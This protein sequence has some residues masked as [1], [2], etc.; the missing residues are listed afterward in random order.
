[1]LYTIAI[2]NLRLQVSVPDS[3]DTAALDKV[4]REFNDHLMTFNGG[5]PVELFE[6]KEI[7]LLIFTLISF[8]L[9]MQKKQD[10]LEEKLREKTSSVPTDEGKEVNIRDDSETIETNQNTNFPLRQRTYQ[11]SMNFEYSPNS[12]ISFNTDFKKF[13]KKATIQIVPCEIRASAVVL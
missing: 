10:E 3:A 8:I 7:K 6:S 11:K 5:K 9:G 13:S 4:I 1:M 2:Q 12:A